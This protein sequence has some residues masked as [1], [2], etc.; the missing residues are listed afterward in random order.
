M[1]LKLLVSCGLNEAGQFKIN[2]LRFAL[3]DI[4]VVPNSL[5]YTVSISDLTANLS[6]MLYLYILVS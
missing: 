1:L 3:C 5:T 2:L 4:V 6:C